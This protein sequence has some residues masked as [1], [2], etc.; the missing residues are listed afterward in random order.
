MILELIGSYIDSNAMKMTGCTS[1]RK[2]TFK[3]LEYSHRNI[4]AMKIEF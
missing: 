3:D 2:M 1:G 4:N